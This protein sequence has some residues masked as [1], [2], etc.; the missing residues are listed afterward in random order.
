MVSSFES[1][2]CMKH[3]LICC[4]IASSSLTLHAKDFTT[5]APLSK[6]LT[7]PEGPIFLQEHGN[8]VAFRNIWIVPAK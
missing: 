4:L 6:P 3:I 7:T 2:I 8:P 1:I 5:S